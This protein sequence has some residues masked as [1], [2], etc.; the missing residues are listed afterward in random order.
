MRWKQ[1]RGPD[2]VPNGLALCT[3]HHKVL[4]RGGITVN[5][6]LRVVVSMQLHGASWIARWLLEQH[7]TVVRAPQSRELLPDPRHLAWH[8]REVFRAPE[9]SAAIRHVAEH[10]DSVAGP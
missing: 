9:R 5:D 8:Q 1:N 10:G 4:D 3:P 7:E 6:D 2:V